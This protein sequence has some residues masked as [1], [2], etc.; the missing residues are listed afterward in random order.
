MVRTD[1]VSLEMLT[2]FI[3]KSG[4]LSGVAQLAA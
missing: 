3:F 4:V 1:G 2:V